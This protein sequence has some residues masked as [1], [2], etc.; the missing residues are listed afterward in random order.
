MQPASGT[1]ETV[2]V[3]LSEKELDEAQEWNQTRM[4]RKWA[5]EQKRVGE[6]WHRVVS[7][8]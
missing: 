1:T 4:E 7:T 8:T 5:N 3:S 2:R 6:E